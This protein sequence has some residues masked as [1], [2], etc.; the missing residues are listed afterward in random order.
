[1]LAVVF[2]MLFKSRNESWLFID[3]IELLQLYKDAISKLR[4]VKVGE[5]LTIHENKHEDFRISVYEMPVEYDKLIKINKLLRELLREN[6]TDLKI[7][8]SAQGI[9]RSSKDGGNYC[10]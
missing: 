7:I 2:I 1:M 6:E 9:L 10:P 3:P 5:S 4:R 8:E